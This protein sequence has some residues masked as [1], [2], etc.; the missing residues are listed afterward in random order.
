[1]IVVGELINTSRKSVAQAVKAYDAGMIQNIAR[2]Q[3]DAG[4]DYI[5]V[6]AGTFVDKEIEYLPWLVETVQAAVSLPLC[7]DSPN[8][9]ALEKAMAAHKGVPMINSISLEPQRYQSMIQLVAGAPCK[10]VALCMKRTAMPDSAEERIEAADEL[11]QGLIEAGLEMDDIYIDPL[12]AA[13]IG[14]YPHGQGGLGRHT[15]RE[16][17]LPV[18]SHNLRFV[19]CLLRLA[20]AQTHQPLFSRTCHARRSGRR[21]FGPDRPALDGGAQDSRHA[22]RK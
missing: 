1:M 5:D 18:C 8:P 12:V 3:A 21:H 13:G 15:R 4:A 9:L 17:R 7:L 22:D 16:K 11:I 6:N 19:Q 2:K 20:R 10:V 14:G